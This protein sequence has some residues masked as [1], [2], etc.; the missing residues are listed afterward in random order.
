MPGVMMYWYSHAR[1]HM[2]MHTSR[3]AAAV[4]AVAVAGAATG[5]ASV[6]IAAAMEAAE[7]IQQLHRNTHLIVERNAH[8]FRVVRK[9]KR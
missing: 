1:M 5:T 4:E 2:H 6:P 3:A 8:L 9:T 7:R